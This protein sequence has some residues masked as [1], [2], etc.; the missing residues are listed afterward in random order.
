MS[1]FK[2]VIEHEDKALGWDDAMPSVR[3][4]DEV[5]PLGD[6]GGSSLLEWL[7]DLPYKEVAE[8]VGRSFSRYNVNV[9][10]WPEDVSVFGTS[11]STDFVSAILCRALFNGGEDAR[12]KAIAWAAE[13]GVAEISNRA[14]LALRHEADRGTEE[15]ARILEA[16]R[17]RCKEIPSRSDEELRRIVLDLLENRIFTSAQIREHDN[18]G[19]VFMPIALGA[20]S[21]PDA[22]LPYVA[23]LPPTPPE[24]EE[25]EMPPRPE[26]PDAPEPPTLAEPDPKKVEEIEFNIRWDR[27]KEG[28]VEEYLESIQKANEEAQ[29]AHDAAVAAVAPAH[30]EAVRKW[31]AE[32]ERRRGEHAAAVEAHKAEMD[33]YHE[34]N[35]E[36]IEAWEAR[37]EFEKEWFMEF[38]SQIG[39]IYEYY[40]KAGPRS[41]NGMPMFMSFSILNADDWKRVWEAYSREAKRREEIQV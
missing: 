26:E 7:I 20:L 39:I 25:P 17:D 16:W 18:I 41:C 29:A 21:V 3:V 5:H 30:E 8:A 23:P 6:K 4:G 14:A 40:D 31:E 24:P 9:E 28:D 33:A 37:E 27:A 10:G 12:A 11:D 32:C 19:M 35:L 36:L 38:A 15:A 13:M 2:P 22:A 34:E 1:E